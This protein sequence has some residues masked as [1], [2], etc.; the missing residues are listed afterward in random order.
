MTGVKGFFATVVVS[1]DST[2]DLGGPKQ[3]FSVGTNYVMNNG[4]Q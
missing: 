1:T 4:Y 3:L 2:T